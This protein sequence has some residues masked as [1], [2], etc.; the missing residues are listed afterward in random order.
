MVTFAFGTVAPVT[1]YTVPRMLPE[2][3]WARAKCA[4]HARANTSKNELAM[5]RIH[6]PSAVRPTIV[7]GVRLPP[8]VCVSQYSRITRT[9]PLIVGRGTPS[10]L[11]LREG[12]IWF[13][14]HPDR[15]VVADQF[16]TRCASAVAVFAAARSDWRRVVQIT[17]AGGVLVSDSFPTALSLDFYGRQEPGKSACQSRSG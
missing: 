5:D 1:S 2:T 14:R 9:G 7:L 16:E 10:R 6:T 15:H 12:Q 4:L 11:N 17:W 3:A 13:D 8:L